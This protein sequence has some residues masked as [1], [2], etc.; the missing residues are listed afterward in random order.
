MIYIFEDGRLVYDKSLLDKDDKY[1]A[2]E[3]LPTIENNG[4]I[5]IYK[6]DLKLG[7]VIVSYLENN[8]SREEVVIPPND[9]EPSTKEELA[10]IKSL[11]DE[12]SQN[13]SILFLGLADMYELIGGGN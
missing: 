1:I 12:N 2:I 3:K 5:P 10:K 6:A 7:K 13:M 8:E 9:N 4:K 11:L